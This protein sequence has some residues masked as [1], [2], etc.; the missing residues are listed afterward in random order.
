MKNLKSEKL[1]L[2][3]YD[4]IRSHIIRNEL[5]PG[6]KLPTEIEMCEMLGVSRNVLRESVKAMELMGMIKS[7]PGKGSIIQE[8][9]MDYIFQNVFHY[10]ISD[11][12][13]LIAEVLDIRKNLELSYMDAA[14]DTVTKEDCVELRE[15]F[16]E[17]KEKWSN[18]EHCHDLDA[19]F[20]KTIFKKLNNRTLN[21][22]FDA[23]WR[24]DGNF[25]M[26][27][28]HKNIA[29]SIKKHQL[30]VE[31]LENHDK[32]AFKEAMCY[33]FSSGKF[34]DPTSGDFEED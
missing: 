23:T 24:A 1:Y 20:H 15:I 32:K 26:P 4:E 29:K 7:C 19:A 30:I 12:N 28:K 6:D 8:L 9:N 16:S 21:A 22:L 3:V 18:Q 31:T 27:E 10:L 11:D 33:H 5:K 13:Q 17:M 25:K 2:Q 14:F 34:F